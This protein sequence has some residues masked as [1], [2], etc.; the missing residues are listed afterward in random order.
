M[1]CMTASSEVSLSLGSL[2]IRYLEW[3]SGEPL[4]LLHGYGGS[5][6]N[7]EAVGLAMAKEYRVIVPSLSHLYTHPEKQMSFEEQSQALSEFI[8]KTFGNQKVHIGAASYGGALAWA[9]AIQKPE[10]VASLT[11]MS[12]MPPHPL[13]KFRNKFLR[14]FLRLGRFQTLLWFYIQTPIGRRALPR[15]A[16]IFQVPWLEKSRGT[17][18]FRSH[19]TSRQLRL[20]VFVIHRFA[21]MIKEEDW[22]YW[23]SRLPFIEAPVCI[24]WGEHDHLYK[25]G[26]PQKMTRIFG[27][28]ELHNI[29]DT[30]HLSMAEN[31]LPVVYIMD[32]FLSRQKRA[33]S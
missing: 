33:A 20:L 12:P 8:T 16:E 26:Q 25:D 11:M 30:G 17:K 29:E 23:E 1:K 19:L 6:G 4:L 18:R 13:P 27:N 10:Q 5:P 31:P 15:M 7:W 14:F 3:G 2:K 24:V 32:R 9:L 22:G 28:A 21:K